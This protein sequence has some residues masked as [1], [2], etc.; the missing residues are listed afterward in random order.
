[1]LVFEGVYFF[2]LVWKWLDF[3]LL[4]RDFFFLSESFDFQDSMEFGKFV[5]LILGFSGIFRILPSNEAS[6]LAQDSMDGWF[7]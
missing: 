3:F 6:E 4:L 7:R 1:M 5:L 2:W